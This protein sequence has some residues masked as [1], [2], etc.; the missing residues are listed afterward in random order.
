MSAVPEDL[1]LNLLAR[2]F[3]RLEVTDLQLNL[4]TSKFTRRIL[5]DDRDL[6]EHEFTDTE[7]DWEVVRRVTEGVAP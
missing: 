3:S 6:G 1:R 5:L 7:V 4:E 2:G